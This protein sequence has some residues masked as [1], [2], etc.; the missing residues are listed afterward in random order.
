MI[1]LL[2]QGSGYWQWDEIGPTDF[3]SY[4]RPIEQLIHGLPSNTDAALT[5]TNGHIYVFKGSQ[6]WRV[7]Q[8]HQA[9]EKAF[10]LST[11]E[12]WMHCD[13]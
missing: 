12:H 5:W 11:A 6:F 4:P 10:P 2:F 8:Q 3:K 9:V 1:H 7:N 13:D